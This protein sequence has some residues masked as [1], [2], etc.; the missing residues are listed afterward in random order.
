MALTACH[1]DLHH[2]QRIVQSLLFHI[3]MLY[4]PDDLDT[5]GVKVIKKTCQL[6]CRTVDIRLYD[7]DPCNI[8][9]LR[10]IFQFHLL[11]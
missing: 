7:L 11:D 2:L 6:Q 8:Y 9:I 3:R 5:S 4:V 10:Y 1:D